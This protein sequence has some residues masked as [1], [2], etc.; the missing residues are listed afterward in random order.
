MIVLA[1]VA[2]THGRLVQYARPVRVAH[3]DLEAAATFLHADSKSG[4]DH[5][6][7][8]EDEHVDYYVSIT[9]VNLIYLLLVAH[10]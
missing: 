4:F 9:I 3:S 1:V 10:S 8:S 2:C 7:I 6:H 5:H